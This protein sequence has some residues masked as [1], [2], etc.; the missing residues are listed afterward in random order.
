MLPIALAGK[1][2]VMQ[3]VLNCVLMRFSA[4]TI[5]GRR[6][7]C[8]SGRTSRPRTSAPRASDSVANSLSNV[9]IS[10]SARSNLAQAFSR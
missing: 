2:L 8:S 9:S 5:S 4:S 7:P 6:S 1:L 10:T 3:P